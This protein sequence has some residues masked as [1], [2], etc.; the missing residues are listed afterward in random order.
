MSE[1]YVVRNL[2]KEF[3]AYKQGLIDSLLRKNVPQLRALENVSLDVKEGEVVGVV[4]ESGSGKTTLGKIMAMIEKPTSG[5]LLFMGKEV[6]DPKEVLKN[7]SMV[8]QNPLTSMNPRM[9]VKDIVSEPLGRYDEDAV[10]DALEKV[11]LEF[12]YVMDKLPR[13]LSGGQLQRVAIA[14]ALS[15]K[16]KFLVLDEPTSALDVSVQAQVL[17]MLA[18]I[19]IEMGLSYLFITHNIAVARFIAD[20]II[21]LYAGKV[22]EIGNSDKVLNDPAH[23]YTRSLVESLPSLQRKEVK[24][25]EGEVPSLINL[26]KGCRFNPRCPMAISICREK[27]PPLIEMGDRK[28][29]CWLYQTDGKEN[30]S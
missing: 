30:D 21:V 9:R 28:V 8:F 12:S 18:D 2:T 17:N 11:G 13:E 7:V 4:G 10:K 16:V 29:A 23:P 19:Q 6:K 26:P 15:R 3:P 1:L 25:P 22:M 24:P 20:K 14:R 27:E 5:E